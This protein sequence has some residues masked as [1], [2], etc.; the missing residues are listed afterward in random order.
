MTM[1]RLQ[2]RDA[3][4]TPLPSG[5]THHLV[6]TGSAGS[7]DYDL[8]VP[9]GYAGEPAPL[10]VMLHGGNQTAADFATGI[11]M[12]ALADEHT[13][14][15]AYPEQSRD[16]NPR[17]FWNWH[18]PGD[19]QADLGEP[20]IIAGITRQIIRERA[21]DPRRVYVAGLSAGGAMSAVMA[22]THPELYAAVGVHSGVPYRAANDL[23]SAFAAMTFGRGDEV[24]GGS[25][26]LIVFHGDRD[27][28]V[29]VVNAERLVT[30]RLTTQDAPVTT[31]EPAPSIAIHPGSADQRPYT[32]TVHT[33]AN[34]VVI[35]ESWIVRG[36]GHSWFGGDPAGSYTDP[37]GPDASAEM[38]RFFLEHPA[39]APP[40][41]A[42]SPRRHGI[43]PWNW[44][45]RSRP[46]VR[47][48]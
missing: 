36:G 45:R 43:W 2:P 11:R 4:R 23:S 35:A 1:A 46:D 6:H 12:N 24:P 33:D 25:A 14:L 15:V 10:V 42:E 28:A 32:R 21:I 9:A 41:V 7:R 3:L 17:G 31:V 27:T 44:R 13:L 19:Q 20:A 5:T 16:A 39:P 47:S 22:A 40:S 29:A 48:R 26:P 37:L 18:R 30:A 34:N 38:V 8:Y